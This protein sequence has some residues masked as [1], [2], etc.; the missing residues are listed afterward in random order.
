MI[1]V[2]LGVLNA[3][4]K[5][6][7]FVDSDD[8]LLPGACENAVRL[9]E[10][11]G[12]D[13]LQF[14]MKITA[15]PGIDITGFKKLIRQEPM[16]SEGDRI[17]YDCYALHRFTH[18]YFNKIYHGEVCHAAAETMPDVWIRQ[19]ADLYLT[20]FFLYRAKTF[21]SITDIYYE[22][23]F[24]NGISTHTPDAKQFAD[25]CTS[26][27]IVPAIEWFL[28]RENTLDKNQFLLDAIK[29]II[30]SD[31]VNKLLALPEITMETVDLAVK[32]WGS[33]VIYDFLKATG[34]LDFKCETRHSLIPTLVNQIL[35][36]NN[37]SASIKA[38]TL[39]VNQPLK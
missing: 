36:Q 10:Q 3:K 14:G 17:L 28:K 12:V 33:E 23:T 4:G 18:H 25:N 9:I 27:V 6:V 37:P 16:T 35:K 11:Y 19:F 2:K 20:F 8:V 39:S 32:S 15:Q 1:A 13:V 22:Y 29:T 5:Y 38:V 21:R 31:V 34:V 7:M 30:K 26:S 24:G